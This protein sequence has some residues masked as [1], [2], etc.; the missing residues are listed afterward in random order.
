MAEARC[1]LSG[2]AFH[3]LERDHLAGNLG[4]ALDAT[5]DVNEI[6]PVYFDDVACRVPSVADRLGRLN[7]AGPVVEQVTLHDVRSLDV[8]RPAVLDTGNRLEEILHA[9]DDLTDAADAAGH[10]HVHRDD[11]RTFRHPVAF[12]DADAELVQPEP[13]HVVGQLFRAGH[14]VAQA[15]EVIGMRV[16]AV[17]GQEGRCA[18]EHGAVPVVDDLGN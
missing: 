10:G 8:Q 5:P 14:D 11:G 4:E 1:R 3:R 6:V 7:D 13:A 18:E 15:P 12:Q 16:F 2:Y 9:G 17:V